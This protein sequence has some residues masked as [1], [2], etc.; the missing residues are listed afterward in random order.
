[1]ISIVLFIVIFLSFVFI[2]IKS[3]VII[4]G[5]SPIFA[6]FGLSKILLAL[7]FFYPLGPL[8]LLISGGVVTRIIV[9]IIAILCYLPSLLIASRQNNVFERAGT[10]RVFAAQRSLSYASTG[11]IVGLLYTTIVIIFSVA[12]SGIANS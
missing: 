11:A 12:V 6:E 7:V 8:I 2:A 1:M 9:F 5:S 4:K 10:D 3:F